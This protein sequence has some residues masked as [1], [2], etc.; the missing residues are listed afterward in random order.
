MTQPTLS[1]VKPKSEPKSTQNGS[2]DSVINVERQNFEG[3]RQRIEEPGSRIFGNSS[4]LISCGAVNVYMEIK[5]SHNNIISI[6]SLHLT[7]VGART[8]KPKCC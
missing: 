4:T 6:I 1:L 3:L 8:L 7:F 5:Q 2:E